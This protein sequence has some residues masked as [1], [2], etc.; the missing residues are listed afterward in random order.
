MRIFNELELLHDLRDSPNVCPLITAFRHQDQ[1]VA[2]LP[3]FQ[4]RDFRDYFRDL[5]IPDMRMGEDVT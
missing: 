2:I 5:T 4:H 3:Y 1:V